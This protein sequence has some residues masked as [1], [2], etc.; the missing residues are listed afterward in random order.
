MLFLTCSAMTCAPAESVRPLPGPP[1]VS[2][3]LHRDRLDLDLVAMKRALLGAHDEGR[4]DREL[5][6]N[7][8]LDLELKS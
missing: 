4:K 5:L 2:P 3:R 8:V 6:G 1:P 7:F